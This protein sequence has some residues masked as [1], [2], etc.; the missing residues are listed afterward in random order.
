MPAQ[1]QAFSLVVPLV[2]RAVGAEEEARIA[3]GGGAE[4]RLPIALALQ[5]RQAVVVRPDAAG[6]NR[7]AIVQQMLRRDG[8]GDAGRAPATNS[9]RARRRDVLEHHAQAGKALEQGLQHRIDEVSFTVEHIDIG[10]AATSPCTSKRHADF[11]H[12]REHPV[13]LRD[14]GDAGIRVGRRAGG[15]ELDAVDESPLARARSISSGARGVGQIQRQQ[16]FEARP[17][18]Q[19]RQDAFAIRARQSPWW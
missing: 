2:R 10:R 19:R 16:R 5:D 7:V 17:G 3:A 12:A 14:V 1:P 15:I 9:H 6:E 13:H 4:Q 11:F 8:R 18:R